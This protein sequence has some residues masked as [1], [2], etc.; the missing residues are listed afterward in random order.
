MSHIHVYYQGNP[1]CDLLLLLTKIHP[2]Y[3]AMMQSTRP[4][5]EAAKIMQKIRLTGPQNV[6]CYDN[7][8][9]LKYMVSQLYPLHQHPSW[10]SPKRRYAWR[11]GWRQKY[12]PELRR[13][14]PQMHLVP[15]S[16]DFKNP[17]STKMN[18][19]RNDKMEG[20]TKNDH[21]KYDLTQK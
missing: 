16:L 13:L 18:Q 2:N 14:G 10:Y 6:H 12:C 1:T 11:L 7:I 17:P 3:A 5:M 20:I 8:W 21:L 9:T 15:M 19:F 4:W